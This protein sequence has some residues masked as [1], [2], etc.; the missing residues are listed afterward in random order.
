VTKHHSECQSAKEGWQVG[1]F[2]MKSHANEGG[3]H[4]V[5]GIN[6]VQSRRVRCLGAIT[7][8]GR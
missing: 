2:I 1:A 5:R 8:I 6:S 4:P 3:A 7:G